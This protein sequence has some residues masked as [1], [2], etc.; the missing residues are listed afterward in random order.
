MKLQYEEEF[1]ESA[2][3]RCANRRPERIAPQQIARFNHERDKLYSILDP[4]DRN[5]AFFQLHL[6]SFREWGLER[7]LLDVVAELPLLGE[8]L[9]SLVV[10]RTRGKDEEGAELYVNEAGQRTGVLALRPEAFELEEALQDSLRHELHHLHD[11][12]D[13]AFGYEPTL[14]LPGLNAAQRRLAR[15]RYRMLWGLTIDAR[16]MAQG[17]T[18]VASR[19]QHR[20]SFEHGYSFWPEEDRGRV[21]ESLWSGTS[22]RHADLVALVCDPRN[23]RLA[24]GP[25]PGA[26]CPLCGFPTFDWAPA[27][28]LAP[29][30]S[31]RVLSEF[32]QWTPEQ[33][34]CLR[35]REAYE[36]AAK[37]GPAPVPSGE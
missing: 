30:V 9:T 26:S 5:A 29:Q 13:P 11:M 23:L 22:A 33:G 7:T 31:A 25:E 34:L 1:I 15:E 21:F 32:P 17:K 27:E 20:R 12:L 19:E 24:Q 18:P 4:D 35:C 37:L 3:F 36:V 8:R 16:L 6:R 28:S 10:R 2:V 14:D